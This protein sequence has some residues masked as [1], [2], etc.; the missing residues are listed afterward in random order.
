MKVTGEVRLRLVNDKEQQLLKKLHPDWS[1]EEILALCTDEDTGWQSN[2][3]TD[4]VRRYIVT[5]AFIN[6]DIFLHETV[7]PANVRRYSVQFLFASAALPAVRTP[8]TILLDRPALLQTYTVQFPP[9]GGG[10]ADRDINTVG[11]TQSTSETTAQDALHA[12]MAY[13]T[14][15]ST[16]T[17]TTVQAA[18]V[19]YKVSWALD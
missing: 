11:L 1:K 12:I 19:Q 9:L 4:F 5:T 7:M 13:T 10:G 17:Q 14:L 6:P 3:V 18:D 15:A 2:I 16:V 8:D